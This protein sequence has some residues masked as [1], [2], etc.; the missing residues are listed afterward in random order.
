ME[1]R[2][3][4]KVNITPDTSAINPTEDTFIFETPKPKLYIKKN[5]TKNP[6]ITNIAT[7]YTI[8]HLLKPY[9][10]KIITISI[11]AFSIFIY[12]NHKISN[13]NI[14]MKLLHEKNEMLK[15]NLSLL[16][17][18]IN[19]KY[20]KIENYATI[21][22]GAYINYENTSDCYRYGLFGYKKSSDPIQI[23]LNTNYITNPF[24][25]AGSS[26]SLSIILND[27]MVVSEILIVHPQTKDRSSAVKDFEVYGINENKVLL[28]E[29]QYE[30]TDRIGMRF[31]ISSEFKFKEIVFVVLNNHG[32]KGYTCI[33]NLQV[34]CFV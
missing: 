21:E 31:K 7:T 33:Y 25:F 26:G 27:A 24:V 17:T 10:Y 15:H 8:S 19:K 9:I 20:I 12:S 32:K 30:L 18:K 16:E 2:K 4:L 14:D 3:T 13:L 5:I 23:L 29:F 6:P 11:I 28:G 22:K 34:F 1:R